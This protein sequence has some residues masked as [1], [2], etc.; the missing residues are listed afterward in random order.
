MSNKFSR[1]ID[2]YKN[3]WEWDS[4][5][6][7]YALEASQNYT[8][9]PLKI[10]AAENMQSTGEK[11]K[12]LYILKDLVERIESQITYLLTMGRDNLY[13]KDK[14]IIHEDILIISNYY[15]QIKK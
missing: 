9:Y 8:W 4:K 10:N 13:S 1:G 11:F 3:L 2:S 6:H 14:D 5:I 15:K 12:L 7:K